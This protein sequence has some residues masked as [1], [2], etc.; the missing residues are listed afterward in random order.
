VIYREKWRPELYEDHLRDI[1]LR[2][3]ARFGSW[4]VVGLGMIL[5]IFL[6]Y[7]VCTNVLFAAAD[8]KSSE[9]SLHTVT[10]PGPAMS[11]GM[12]P[13][14]FKSPSARE[15]L[16][17]NIPQS[18]ATNALLGGEGPALHPNIVNGISRQASETRGRVVH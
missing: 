6:A 7:L 18:R 13:A 12:I 1:V 16:R 5:M 14:R 3:P 9:R 10:Q 4:L 11:P 15:V 2:R 8:G 17:T